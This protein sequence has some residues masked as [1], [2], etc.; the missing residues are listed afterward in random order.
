M[1]I[2]SI[3]IMGFP[4]LTGFYSKD[5][6]LELVYVRF[7]LDSSFVYSFGIFTAFLT[8]VY[9]LKLLLFVFF[10]KINAFRTIL[11][12]AEDSLFLF[13]PLFFL[14]FLSIFVGYIFCDIFVGFGFSF[15]AD[16]LFFFN[17]DLSFTDIELLS[18]L[19]K[20]MPFFFSCMGMLLGF[21]FFYMVQSLLFH[22][23]ILNFL[24]WVYTFLSIKMFFFFLGYFNVIYN[25]FFF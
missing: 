5:L 19:I 9:S 18:P 14:A 12:S 2:G 13:I 8:A 11:N 17:F 25:L 10:Y 16:S 22:F 3:S 15:L 21:L 23:S 24:R 6:L 7:L 20:N 1:F 4:F